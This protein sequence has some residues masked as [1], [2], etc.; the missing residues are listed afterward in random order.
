MFAIAISSSA[1]IV[2]RS[3]S[4]KSAPSKWSLAIPRIISCLSFATAKE[5]EMSLAFSEILALF[6]TAFICSII[7]SLVRNSTPSSLYV[8]KTSYRI[9]IPSL[10]TTSGILP[11]MKFCTTFFIL[12]SFPQSRE[13]L[14]NSSMTLKSRSTITFSVMLSSSCLTRLRVRSLIC[15]EPSRW[16]SERRCAKESKSEVDWGS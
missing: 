11:M 15:W 16:W 1:C 12:S 8:R 14:T 2:L 6:M 3:Y 4:F 13:S 10:A 9:Y 7:S 5:I